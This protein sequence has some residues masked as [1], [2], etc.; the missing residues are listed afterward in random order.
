MRNVWRSSASGLWP[1]GV[2]AG[3]LLLLTVGAGACT[4]LGKGDGRLGDDLADLTADGGP[5]GAFGAGGDF[6]TSAVSGGFSVTATSGAGGAGFG[7]GGFEDG[8]S[9]GGAVPVGFWKFDDCTKSS[10]VLLDSSGFGNT[11]NRTSSVAC[12]A[13]IDGLA[14]DFN[15]NKDIVT[16]A[17]GASFAFTDHVAVAA[18]I[19]PTK[20]TGT[21]SIVAQEFSG[22]S[23]F[24]L[25]IDAGVVQFSVTL[26]GNHVVTS[27]A[28]IPANTWSHVAG[29]YDGHFL[30]LYLDGQ[31]VGQDDFPGTLKDANGPIEIGNDVAE[32]HFAGAIDDVWISTDTVGLSDIAALSCI[33]KPPTFVATPAAGPPSPPDSSVDYSIVVTNNNAGF[34]QPSA[35]AFNPEAPEGFTASVPNS[36]APSVAPGASATFAMTVTAGEPAPGVYPIPFFVQDF[37]NFA[38]FLQ[39][40]VTYDLVAPTGCFAYISRELML[41]DLSIV[42]DPIRTTWTGPPSDP[43][44]G[45]W[46]FATLMENLAPTPEAAPAMVQQLVNTWLTDQTV[47]GFTVAA[48]P[49]IQALV[50]DPWPKTSDGA[51]DLTQAPLRLSAIVNRLDV[52]NLDQGKAGEGRFVFG[53]L[54]QFGNPQQ[55]T[56]IVEYALPATTDADV[57]TWANA[58]HGLSSNPFPSEQYNAALQAL[59][60]K[61]TGRNASPGQPNGSALAQLR[62]NEI[63]LSFEWELREFHLSPTTGLLQEAGVALTPDLSLDQTQPVGDFVNQNQ[64]AIL[65]QIFTVP[66]TFEGAP[67]QGGSSLNPFT[68]WSAPGIVDNDARQLFSLNTCNGCHGQ[69]TGTAFLQIAPRFPGQEAQLSGFL[70]GIT[71]PDP[72]SGVT[73]TFG[74]LVARQKDL[75]SLVCA[76]P[77]ATPA[78]AAKRKALIETGRRKVH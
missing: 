8:G 1:V 37:S 9:T 76:P 31:Q 22:K 42:E 14:V 6:G 5:G 4:A 47:N 58:W 56:L 54:D 77:P 78:A 67:F 24:S 12:V 62:T 3:A 51:L 46:T 7:G 52:R 13:G 72:V 68:F 45:A 65:T 16:V 41:T 2:P 30:F 63:A 44:T 55:F 20:V 27:S 11:A 43:R 34:C 59:T 39:G 71:L 32:D 36:F 49:E 15:A 33:Q 18:W 53:V 73:R 69:E 29:T 74:D 26:K 25:A 61:F 28:P 23:T 48:R 19:N 21:H 64:A 50:I 10:A 75:E 35:Y 40:Q 66:P 60:T 57:L 70:T 17:D 38:N